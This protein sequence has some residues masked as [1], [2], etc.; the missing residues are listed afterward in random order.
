MSVW[1]KGAPFG[2]RKVEEIYSM[3]PETKGGEICLT[4]IKFLI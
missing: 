1:A 4:Y 2:R 3:T